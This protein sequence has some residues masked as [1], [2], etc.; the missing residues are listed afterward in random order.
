M[1]IPDL[2]SSAM[3]FAIEVDVVGDARARNESFE[4]RSFAENH[5]P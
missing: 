4:G 3:N 1:A 2:G 5:G